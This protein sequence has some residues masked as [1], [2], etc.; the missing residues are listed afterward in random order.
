MHRP[1]FRFSKTT[2]LPLQTGWFTIPLVISRHYFISAK[3]L[4]ML[5]SPLTRWIRGVRSGFTLIELLVVIAIIAILI[6]LLLPAVQKVREAAGRMSCSNNLK[7]LA[8]AAHSYHDAIGG[9]PYGR[10]TDQYNAYTWSA[11][12]LPYIEQDNKYKGMTGIVNPTAVNLTSIGTDQPFNSAL[13]KS[14][15]CP[16]DNAAMVDEPNSGWQR[17]RGNYVGC[18]GSG[19]MYGGALTPSTGSTSSGGIFLT[20]AGQPIGQAA[21]CKIPQIADGTSNTVMFSEALSP[22]ISG[23]GGNPGDIMLGNM[24]SALFS[25]AYPPNTS[26]ADLLRGNADGDSAV[27]P[28]NHGDPVYPANIC[29]WSGSSQ[30]NSW[31]SARSRHSGGV[32]TGRIVVQ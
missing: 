26:V 28:Q 12:I 14:Y 9:L 29:T 15:A 4:S 21:T 16:S 8:L 18:V 10:K 2:V 32:N 7:Q 22:S 13:V 17:N 19:N 5:S 3:D 25:T 31:A 1:F 20:N 30:A 24:G 23:W 11:V 27:C 6:G